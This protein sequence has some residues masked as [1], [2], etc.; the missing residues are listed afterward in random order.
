MEKEK[1]EAN[2]RVKENYLLC[3]LWKLIGFHSLDN[4]KLC[5]NYVGLIRNFLVDPE[6]GSFVVVVISQKLV[7]RTW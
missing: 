1:C 5:A 7:T 4:S 3:L 2:I 6:D